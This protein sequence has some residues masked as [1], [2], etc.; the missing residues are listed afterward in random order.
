MWK[1]AL[2]TPWVVS[3]VVALLL[4]LWVKWTLNSFMQQL[5][6]AQP[7]EPAQ[8]AQPS[9]PEKPAGRPDQPSQ[10]TP[11]P[12]TAP[13]DHL[14]EPDAFDEEPLDV[15]MLQPAPVQARPANPFQTGMPP[16]MPMPLNATLIRVDPDPMA[17]SFENAE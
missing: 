7:G 5:Q 12:P 16:P 13:E 4:A 8:P 6:T 1:K 2:S 3:T 9:Q 10:P 11:A 17:D 15:R 14:P